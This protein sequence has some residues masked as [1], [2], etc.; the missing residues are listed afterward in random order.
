MKKKEPAHDWHTEQFRHLLESDGC[1]ICRERARNAGEHRFWFMCESYGEPTVIDKIADAWGFCLPHA[2]WLGE[3]S[4]HLDQLTYV[5]AFVSQRVS[6]VLAGWRVR[7][8]TAGVPITAQCPICRDML[9]GEERNAFFLRKFLDDPSDADRYGR[10]GLLC[11]PHFRLLLPP[12]PAP[13]LERMVAIH[14][15]ALASA[16]SRLIA[17]NDD[18]ISPDLASPAAS[19]GVVLVVNE[20]EGHALLP[21]AAAAA[22]AR[23]EFDPNRDFVPRLADASVCPVCAEMLRAWSEW[24]D[25]LEQA[26]RK[27]EQVDDLLPTCPEHVW[28]CAE[29]GSADLARSAMR[30][31]LQ[32]LLQQVRNGTKL[33]AAKPAPQGA[34]FRL[35]LRHWRNSP[36]PRRRFADARACILRPA[37]C[38]V[39]ARLQTAEERA[40]S[41]LLALV[42]QSHHRAAYENGHGLCLRH[43]RRALAGTSAVRPRQF[44][45]EVERA[46]LSLLQW[47]LDEVLRKTPWS[48]RPQA[49]GTESGAWRRAV[50]RFAGSTP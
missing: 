48:A 14:E 17:A 45:L 18:S 9:G 31:T 27:H 38:P 10:P 34:S 25:W 15:R 3:S 1:P 6:R 11:F 28:A 33:L 35:Q 16:Y 22:T 41:L 50:Y 29:L 8:D 40:I 19:P 46:K 36:G 24:I 47:E 13:M 43:F 21:R 32:A 4:S 12:L 7:G 49:K 30:V 23:E 37:G 44:L 2:I 26:V 39:C 20:H 5:Y 42:E